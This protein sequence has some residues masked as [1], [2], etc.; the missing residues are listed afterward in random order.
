MKFGGTCQRLCRR[1]LRLCP[2]RSQPFASLLPFC[3]HESLLLQVAHRR[4]LGQLLPWPS[5]WPCHFLLPRGATFVIVDVLIP[6]SAGMK[7][8]AMVRVSTDESLPVVGCS[9]GAAK[10]HLRL[11]S[12]DDFPAIES[13]M[14]P[15]RQ[16]RTLNQRNAL[17]TQLFARWSKESL[18]SPECCAQARSTNWRP[19]SGVHHSTTSFVA[20]SLR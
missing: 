1:R 12:F 13:Q 17:G 3:G 5:P 14:T 18:I 9:D 19:P 20:S 7:L 10:I 8:K 6:T 2:L 15:V 16:L 11:A 4:L